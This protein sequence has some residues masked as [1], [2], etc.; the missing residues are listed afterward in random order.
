M[1]MMRRQKNITVESS[2]A[3]MW[4]NVNALTQNDV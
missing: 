2:S 4:R 1:M 3:S